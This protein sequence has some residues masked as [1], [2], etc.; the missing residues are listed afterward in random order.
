MET[1]D[2]LVLNQKIC[3]STNDSKELK[4]IDIILSSEEMNFAI[5]RDTFDF[6]RMGYYDK[7]DQR[8]VHKMKRPYF[9]CNSNNRRFHCLNECFRSRFRL[10]RYF[11]QGN[12]TGRILLS[13]SKSN[14]TIQESERIC[15]DKCKIENCKLVQLIQVDHFKKA[16]K[17]EIFEAQPI[18]SEFDFWVEI[19]GLIFSFVS[20]LFDQLALIVTKFIKLRMGRKKMEIGLFSLNLVIIILSLAYCGYLCVRAALDQQVEAND[21]PKREKTRNLI[22]PKVVHLAICVNMDFDFHLFYKGK[23][24]LEIERLTGGVLDDKLEGIFVTYGGRSFRTDYHVHPKVLFKQLSRCFLLSIY[25]N[26]QTIPSRSMLIVKFKNYRWFYQFYVLSEEENLSSE[27][28]WYS[29]RFNFQKRIV[30]KLE[31]KGTCVNYMKKYTNCMGRR[32]CV[33]RC[34]SRKFLERYNKTFFGFFPYPVIDRDWFSPSEWNTSRLIY[35]M[36]KLKDLYLNISKECEEEVPDFKP[37][38]EIKFV[39]TFGIEQPDD[40]TMEI[41]L[42]FDVMRSVEEIPSSLRMASDLLSIQSI[43]FGFTLLQ[44]FWLIY[45][46]IEPKWRFG[47]NNK[48]IWFLVCLLCSIGCSWNTVRM[49]DVIVNGELVLTEHY[50]MAER[51]QMPAMIFCLRIDQKLVDRNHLLTGSY[52]KELTRQMNVS[53]TFKSI[54]Y[55][56]ESNEWTLFDLDRVEQFFFQ[57][58]KCFRVN[59]DKDYSR[60]RFHFSDDTHILSVDFNEKNRLVYFM[61]QSREVAEFSKI[62]NLD[63]VEKE[64]P[65]GLKIEQGFLIMHEASVYEHKDRFGFFRRHFLPLQEGDVGDL[66]NQLLELQGNEPNRRTLNIP[67]EKEHFG[68]EVDEDFFEQL[69]L[70]QKQKNQN[71]HTNLNY[72]QLF[73]ANHLRRSPNKYVSDFKFDFSFH[74]L[75]LQ[76]VVHSTNEVN[77]A[78]LTLGLLNLLSLWLELSMLDLPPFLVRLHNH[79][80][81]YLYLHLPVHLLRRL[82]KALL[83]CR[84]RLRKL[85]PQLLVLIDHRPS[86]DQSSASVSSI[87]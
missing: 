16:P 79:F 29:G 33:E 85:K 87:T 21:L 74:L 18:I 77:Y 25:P 65:F 45:Q 46:F 82:I 12:E 10:A 31:S 48:T 47:S 40:Q 1:G 53:S 19:I 83:F 66:H 50:E 63:Y 86:S 59:I 84:K 4:T 76:R 38:V 44:L 20:L 41:D 43:F 52:L 68:L 23:T 56:N 27:S 26:Y 28:F 60:N 39:N 37:C 72:R 81:V 58:M 42:Q 70:I 64:N 22:H 49:L 2:Y 5:Q 36:D 13:F 54:A 15:F 67:M 3:F 34:I 80:F 62:L 75:F 78:T 9:G 7:I 24:M 61:T 11:Y 69:Y 32:N 6:V 35:K 71:K 73:L 14:Q 17:T 51:I 57:G 55:L 30:R 8:I